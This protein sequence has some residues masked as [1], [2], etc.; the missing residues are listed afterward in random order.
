MPRSL[1]ILIAV[2]LL[3]AGCVPSVHPLFTSADL[4]FDPELIGKWRLDEVTWEFTR[5]G[6]HYRLVMREKKER[7]SYVTAYLL[8]LDGIRYLD[9]IPDKVPGNS[10]QA[11]YLAPLHSFYRM[12]RTGD[13]FRIG[14]LDAEWLKKALERREVSIPHVLREGELL[15]TAPTPELQALVKRLAN[16]KDAFPGGGD[17]FRKLR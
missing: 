4:V 10:F 5:A 11:G 17:E 9:L 3:L 8:E 16:N 6:D 2:A 14:G 12:W 1:P 13:R 15:L 7:I